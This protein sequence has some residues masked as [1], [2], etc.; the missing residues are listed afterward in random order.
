MWCDKLSS[1]VDLKKREI[2]LILIIV[3]E[4]DSLI[5]FINEVLNNVY[6]KKEISSFFKKKVAIFL[7]F[8]KRNTS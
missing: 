3:V 6:I 5:Y 1:W 7:N 4:E 2:S 8:K